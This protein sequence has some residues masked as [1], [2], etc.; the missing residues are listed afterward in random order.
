MTVPLM[1]CFSRHSVGTIL[2]H[3]LQWIHVYKKT[4][5]GK[6]AF[7]FLGS[8]ILTKINHST[9]NVKP[10]ASFRHTLKIEILANYL[11]I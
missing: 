3:K 7:S 9:K 11:G 2:D 8:K 1:T 10:T 5:T 6:Q 4:N